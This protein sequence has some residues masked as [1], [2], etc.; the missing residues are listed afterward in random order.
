MYAG[1]HALRARNADA[2]GMLEQQMVFPY[3]MDPFGFVGGGDVLPHRISMMVLD[4]EVVF[5]HGNV[6]Y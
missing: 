6:N 2:A 4:H 5:F 3:A 1:Q